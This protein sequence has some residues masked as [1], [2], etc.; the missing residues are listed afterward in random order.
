MNTILTT[1][2]TQADEMAKTS[3]SGNGTA[4]ASTPVGEVRVYR[5]RNVKCMNMKRMVLKTWWKLDG[6][7]ISAAKMEALLG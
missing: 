6:K 5:E 4:A 2:I 3:R 1:I 7:V